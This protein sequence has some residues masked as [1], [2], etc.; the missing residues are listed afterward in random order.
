VSGDGHHAS[1]P[2]SRSLD[3]RRR[4][5]PVP[6]ARGRASRR[7]PG[8]RTDP[9]SAGRTPIRPHYPEN[10]MRLAITR[11]I[12]MSSASRVSRDP[13][14][15]VPNAITMSSGSAISST[16]TVSGP[17]SRASPM[18]G[19]RALPD[20]HRG[21]RTP[22]RRGERPTG[23]RERAPGRSACPRGR[24]ARPSGGSTVQLDPLGL[25]EASIRPGPLREERVETVRPRR[26]SNRGGLPSPRRQRATRRTLRSPPPSSRSP[27]APAPSGSP[28]RGC[29]G[30]SRGRT[31]DGE[32]GRSLLTTTS[33][34]ARNISGYLS[35]LSSPSVTEQIMA[36]RPHRP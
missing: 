33:S 32:A 24:N 36:G 21:A 10:A 15:S 29:A 1:R 13:G 35:G 20:D 18:A 27:R 19:S 3:A 14:S 28:S 5:G 25:E 16:W 11:A 17:P 7:A 30:A 9:R 6:R 22:R 8:G 34:Q 4:R 23:P 26:R 31:P 12:A 2:S